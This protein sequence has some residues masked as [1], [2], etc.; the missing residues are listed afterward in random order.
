MAQDT[1]H[2]TNFVEGVSLHFICR[3]RGC[4][5][6]GM[7]DGKTWVQSRLKYKFRCPSCGAKYHP[8]D[9]P[10]AAQFVLSIKN[11]ETDK[12]HFIPTG[13]PPKSINNMVELYARDIKVPEDLDEDLKKWFDKTKLD[14][15]QLIERESIP[16][17]FRHFEWDEDKECYIDPF[18]WDSDHQRLHGFWGA[19]LM[20]EIAV[21]EPYSNWKELIGLIANHVV[22]SRTILSASN[23]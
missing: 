9:N 6:F 22:A 17:Q 21:K 20:D 19:K 12:V 7:N 8:F 14:L 11:A 1:T 16:Q 4:R 5:F 13:W 18:V 23:L 2:L 10:D 3:R 15:E